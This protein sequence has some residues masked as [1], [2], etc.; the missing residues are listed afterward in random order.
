VPERL[1]DFAWESDCI[2]HRVYG[3]ALMK[4]D[5]KSA[6]GV[7]VWIKRDRGLIVDKMYRTNYH[8]N[9]GEFMD[10]YRVGTS[11]GC[12]GLGIWD[13]KKLHTS[14]NY[15]QWELLTSGPIRSEFELAY[16][17]WDVGNHRTVSAVKHMSIDAG[18]WFTKVTTHFQSDDQRPLTVGVGLAERAGKSGKDQFVETSRHEG[19][20]TYWQPADQ[21]KGT[22]GV[23]I[24]LP[25]QK[26]QKFARDILEKP[27]ETS[28]PPTLEG[29]PPVENLLAITQINVSDDFTYYLGAC[30][31]KSGDFTNHVAWENNTKRFAACLKTPLQVVVNP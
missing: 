14:N 16:D 25:G 29:L 23:A 31:S 11:C 10:D 18:S 5:G 1:D 24:V 21:A 6:S 17:S 4:S 12:G 20:M 28:P 22:I 27:D 15:K 3:Q 13:G 8:E 7:D 9:N 26:I 19:W 2:A 30:W